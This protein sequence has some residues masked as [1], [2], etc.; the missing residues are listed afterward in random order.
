M[1]TKDRYERF[2]C[3]LNTLKVRMF[4]LWT[5]NLTTAKL[6]TYKKSKNLF[7]LASVS[8]FIAMKYTSN[9]NCIF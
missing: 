6:L 2:V 7:F 3:C 4:M 5:Y 8:E 1:F 9:K